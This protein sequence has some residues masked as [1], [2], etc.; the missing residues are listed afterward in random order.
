[1]PSNSAVENIYIHHPCHSVPSMP[2]QDQTKALTHSFQLASK[3]LHRGCRERPRIMDDP[4][5]HDA[6]ERRDYLQIAI[7]TSQLSEDWSAWT[8]IAKDTQS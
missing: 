3:K 4:E 1:M 2:V 6:M 8:M 5:V 7:E